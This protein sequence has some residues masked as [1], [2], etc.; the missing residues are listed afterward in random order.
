MKK[1]YVVKFNPEMNVWGLLG[2]HGPT[3][4]EEIVKL[5]KEKGVHRVQ[6]VRHADKGERGSKRLEGKEMLSLWKDVERNKTSIS[7]VKQ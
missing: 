1:L 2:Q 6:H 7:K 3:S 5:I 4:W